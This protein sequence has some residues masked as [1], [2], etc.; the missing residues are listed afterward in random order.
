MCG[1]SGYISLKDNLNEQ[2]VRAMTDQII[3]RG[4]DGFGYRTIDNVS[5]GH[6]RLSIIDLACGAQPMSNQDQTIWITY[7]GELYNYIDLKKELESS[8][9]VFKSNSDTE[10][11]IYAYQKWGVNCLNKFRGMFAFGIIDINKKQVFAARDHFG[12]KPLYIY[13]DNHAVAFAS[14]LQQFKV[15]PSFDRTINITAL[16]NYLWLQYIPAPLTIFEKA[17]KLKPAHY[18]LISFD[19]NISDQKKYWNL[20][21]SKKKIKTAEEWKEAT[22]EKIKESVNAHLVADVPFGAFL[23][24]GVDSTLVVK[25]MSETLKKPVKTFSIGFDDEAYNE[26]K[27]AELASKK[28]NTDHY[29]EIVK[30]DALGLLPKLVKHYGEPFGDSSALPTY[31]VCELARKHVKMVLSGDGGDE[32]FA[33]YD[34]Y[35][36]WMKML[37][38]NYRSG[39]KK[40]IY[41][42]LEKLLPSRYEKKDTLNNWLEQINYLNKN[43]RTSLWKKDMLVNNTEFP[44]GF[45]DAFNSTNNFSMANKVQYMDL[46]TYMPYDILTKVDVASMIHSLEVRTPLI[47]KELWEFAASIPEEF[48]INKNET[49]WNGKMV[50]KQLL[51]NDFPKDFIYRNKQGF[52]VPL[53]K[54]FS[55]RGGLNSVLHDKLLSE[56]SELKQYFNTV[57]LTQLIGSENT[58]G[59]WLLLFLHEWLRQFKNENTK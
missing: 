58:G 55:K 52:A 12:I 59:K 18:V 26:L 5:I 50:L 49:K 19:G 14:E 30:P 45:E 4:P 25:Y 41:P 44:E 47:D 46:K 38:V 32:G 36:A 39:F 2:V 3:H 6:R 28:Y 56:D 53:D 43:W 9:V 23:S 20:S 37:P 21:F 34:S 48:L 42:A 11:I 51:E 29:I 13:K 15:I 1:I 8:G 7:N 16:D 57:T 17:K 35:I 24:G 54:W 27:Y 10:V 40:K 22:G 33:G 31:Y